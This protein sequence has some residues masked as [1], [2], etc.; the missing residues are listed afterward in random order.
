VLEAFSRDVPVDMALTAFTVEPGVGSWRITAEGQAEGPNAAAA[1]AT[2]NRFLKALASSPLLG[3]PATPPSLSVHTKDAAAG[4]GQRLTPTARVPDVTLAQSTRHPASVLE[5][6][7]QYE[8]P[9]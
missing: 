7:I 8:V 2:F 3:N 1:Q 4:V 6:T 9:K 5:F